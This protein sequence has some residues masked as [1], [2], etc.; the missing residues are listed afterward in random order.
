MLQCFAR[1]MLASSVSLGTEEEVELTVQELQR[2][3]DHQV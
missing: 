2:N 1:Q 3:H